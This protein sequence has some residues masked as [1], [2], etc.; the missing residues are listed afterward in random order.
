MINFKN[1]NNCF[2]L[3]KHRMKIRNIHYFD[4]NQKKMIENQIKKLTNKIEKYKQS[5]NRQEY[6]HYCDLYYVE[7]IN[8]NADVPPPEHT[9]Y[10]TIN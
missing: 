6:E 1:V 2:T 4:K 3:L 8:K 9:Q 10:A 5:F 7:L